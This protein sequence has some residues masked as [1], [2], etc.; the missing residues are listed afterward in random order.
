M[1]DK[2]CVY[3]LAKRKESLNIKTPTRGVYIAAIC[4]KLSKQ[5]LQTATH[6]KPVF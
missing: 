2:R 1:S 6:E 4:F 3:F 5:K